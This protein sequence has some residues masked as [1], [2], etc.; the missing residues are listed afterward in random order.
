MQG[1]PTIG[2]DGTK[3]AYGQHLVDAGCPHW[4]PAGE[5]DIPIPGVLFLSKF[6]AIVNLKSNPAN[7]VHIQIF[8][9]Y[10]VG[11]NPGPFAGQEDEYAVYDENGNKVE[12][13]NKEEGSGE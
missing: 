11:V 8:I 7:N 5:N 4:R 12:T 13:S 10:Y 3:R 1:I 2:D 9:I 6:G